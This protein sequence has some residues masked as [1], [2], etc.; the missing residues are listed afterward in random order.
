MDKTEWRLKRNQN[1][2][3]QLATFYLFLSEKSPI[4]NAFYYF[5]TFDYT[6]FLFLSCSCV[7]ST[8]KKQVINSAH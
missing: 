1:G 4:R 2:G 6:Y 3:E 7:L 5:S 8:S